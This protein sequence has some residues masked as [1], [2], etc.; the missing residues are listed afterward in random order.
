[1]NRQPT[2][3]FS[4]AA[5]VITPIA[6]VGVFVF[7]SLG[8][9]SWKIHRP[10][11]AE[12]LPWFLGMKANTALAFVVGGIA[13]WLRRRKG[14]PPAADVAGRILA[15][16]VIAIGALALGEYFFNGFRWFDEWLL[17]GMAS[18]PL[19]G[20]MS[21]L[22]AVNFVLMGLGLLL[23]DAE[24]KR[25]PQPGQFFALTA[26]MVSLLAVIGYIVHLG[27][28]YGE[29][30]QFPGTRMAR[31]TT[32]CFLILGTGVL[33]ARPRGRVMRVLTSR[34]DGGLMLRRLLLLPVIVPLAVGMVPKITM[35][36]HLSNPHINA[37][38]YAFSDIFVFTLV[39]WWNGALLYRL[40]LQRQAA[41]ERLRTLNSELERRVEE[42]S[43]Q[44]LAANREL[45]EE[46]AERRHAEELV[47]KLNA[48]LEQRVSDRTAQIH[49]AYKELESFSYSVSHD[50]RAPLR[51]IGNYSTMLL[52]DNPQLSEES[53]RYVKSAQRSVEKMQQLIDDLLAFA[54]VNHQ[55]LRKQTVAV[56]EV[57]RQC[58]AE[59]QS[60]A[61]GRE[62]NLTVR[63]NLQCQADPSLLKQL[64]FN[65]LSNAIKFTRGRER[66]MIEV[67]SQP[68]LHGHSRP[69]FF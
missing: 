64:L 4:Q 33:C 11:S 55:A 9:V 60:E 34:T 27:I 21:Y 54:R 30:S 6:A 39:F 38:L 69:A 3:R 35:H 58:F 2:E 28:Y 59:L 65:L 61:R 25:G 42:R 16:G 52:E 13:L 32:A 17:K 19:P 12:G 18:D 41:E 29:T 53:R 23:M 46:V 7:G 68:S 26:M 51:A 63:S 67:G 20:R 8:L 45:R 57:A 47:R 44:V 43:G 62:I 5:Q 49:T 14:G 15:V 31:M 56:D 1:M 10:E 24:P 22:T 40:D 48:N 37:W 66:A 36:F 50:L